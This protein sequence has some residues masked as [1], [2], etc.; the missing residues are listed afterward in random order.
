MDQKQT[1]KFIA[2]MRRERGLTQKELADRLLI[3]DKTVSKWECG[4][5][6]PEVGLILPL[7]NELGITANELLSG[8][9]LTETEY[10]KNA[11]ENIVNLMNEKKELKLKVFME[12][13]VVLITI[14]AGLA[15]CMVAGLLTIP[16]G[17]RVA[18]IV[19]ALTVIFVG[20]V[21]AFVLERTAFAFKCS[22]CGNRFVP[23][24]GAYI[25]GMHTI[26]KRHLKCPKCGVRN[27]CKICPKYEIKEN[28]QEKTQE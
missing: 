18:L 1:G 6:F 7:C 14:I 16:F 25:M 22:H 13:A 17:W 2:E 4:G 21:S 19:I 5:G 12:V 27:W 24:V 8:K 28:K 15:L 3:S 9:K 20:I 23:T 26:T 10:K 11:E